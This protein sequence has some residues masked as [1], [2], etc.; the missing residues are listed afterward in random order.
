ADLAA[1]LRMKV[2]AIKNSKI[3]KSFFVKTGDFFQNQFDDNFADAIATD[4]PW[5]SYQKIGGDFYAN[6]MNEFARIL[7]PGGR[8][9]VLTAREMILPPHEKLTRAEKFDVLIHGKKATVHI[10]R[11]N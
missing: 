9:V 7:K 5:G 4:P 10:Y 6:T 1:A 3:Q 11:A 2:R 8:L